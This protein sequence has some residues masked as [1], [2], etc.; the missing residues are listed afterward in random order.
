MADFDAWQP[1]ASMDSLRT[2]A[3]VMA[4]VRGFFALRNVLEVETPML[5]QA[6]VTDVNLR[7]FETRFSHPQSSQEQVLYLQTSPE[8]AMKRLL[9]AGSGSIY[10]LSKAFRNEEAGRFHNPEFTMLEWYR[11]GFDHWQLID[12]VDALLQ[13]VLDTPPLE[14]VT[15]QQAFI[16]YCDFDPLDIS[17]AHL[18]QQTSRLGFNDIAQSET[19]KDVLL[20]L[21][22]CELIEPQLSQERPVA[23]VN[24]PASQ[25]A[26][27]KLEPEDPRIA[28]RF[29]VY[30]KGIE[31]ANG[32]HE[33]GDPQE[34]LTRFENDNLLRQSKGL[35]TITIDNLF[36]QAMHQGLPDCAGVALGFD[37]LM[38][39]KRQSSRI[40]QTMSFFIDNA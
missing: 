5:S 20:Q 4:Q 24:F 7:A 23:L 1:T 14:I 19:N 6:S 32:Y 33:L 15:Y 36:I 11:V 38:M 9:C 17:L 2:R 28:R 40:E 29:E 22:C 18:Q 8:F 25:A 3:Q 12:E 13:E 31:L 30:Y 34:Q 26:L 35:P 27:A 21:L 37:R 10:Q 39:L 16:R